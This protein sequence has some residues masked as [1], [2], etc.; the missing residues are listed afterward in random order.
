MAKKDDNLYDHLNQATA[1]MDGYE[2]I[3]MQTQAIP[4]I[5]LLQKM[6]PQCDETAEEYMKDAKPGLFLN[7]VTNELY[8]PPL[9]V[10]VG[11]FQHVFLEF[12]PNRGPFKGTHAPE[13]IYQQNYPRDEKSNKLYNPTTNNEYIEAYM[14]YVIMPDFIDDGV[15]IMSLS[16]TAI[17]EARRLNRMLVSTLI[18]N[19]NKKAA[20]YFMVWNC[21]PVGMKNEKGSWYGYKFSLESFVTPGLLEHTTEQRSTMI[22]AK[23]DYSKAIL[24]D[25]TQSNDTAF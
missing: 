3:N 2:D 19:T 23:V 25:D 1:E 10:V 8:A 7:S 20:P 4:F 24:T 5:R 13:L 18:P 11:R 22:D 15:C 6:S 17:K 14:Y 21:E 16:S 12:A 9:R